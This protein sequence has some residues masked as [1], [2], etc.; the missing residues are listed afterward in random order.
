MNTTVVN[1]I[2]ELERIGWVYE[3]ASESEVRCR[4][5]FHDDDT[6]SCSINIER[7][8][9]KCHTAGCEMKGD[10]VTFIARCLKTSRVVALADLATRYDLEEVKPIGSRVVERYHSAI[11]AA[12]PHLK[13]L[14]DRGV[15]VELIRKYR[16]GFDKGRI[17]IPITNDGGIF[18]NV[19]R[20]MPG[21]PG[22]EKMRN[23]RGHGK[24]RLFPL[25]QLKYDCVIIAGGELKAIVAADLLNEHNIG[26]ITATAGEGNWAPAFTARLKGKRIYVCMD[27][28]NPGQVAADKLCAQ[29][30]GQ[31]K[32]VGKLELPLDVDKYPAGDINDWV[33]QEKA[34]AEDFLKLLESTE[35]WKPASKISYD[36]DEL[37]T[38]L[39]LAQSVDAAFTGRRVKVKAVISAVDTAPYVVPKR[40][41]VSCGRDQDGCSQCP[42]FAT[43][44]GKEGLTDMLLSPES[45]GILEMVAAPKKSQR[46]A[47]MSGLGVPFCKTVEFRP[48][49]YFN[50][51]DVRLSPQLE[52]TCKQADRTMQPAMCIGHGLE[53]NE[54]YELVGRMYPHPKSQQSVLMISSSKATQ[55]AL[56]NYS[57]TDDEL[58]ELTVFQPTEWTEDGVGEKLDEIYDDL[59]A[60]VTRIFKRRDL[61]LALDLAYHSAL[62]IRFDGR[63][64][65]GWV[66]V[67]VVGDSAQGKSETTIQ[68]MKHYGLGEKLECK[69]A[70]VAGMLGGLQQL[71]NR[72]FITWGVIP[73]HD[74][75][76]VV[77]EELKGA[78][79]E[80]IGKLTDMRS[81]GIAEIPK[82]ERRR[83]HAR[84]RLVALSNPRSSSPM[85]S[86]NFGVEAIPELIGSLED[87]RRFDLGII[88]AAND[89][90]AK[91]L[92]SLQRHRPVVKP[93]YTSDLCRRCVL[94]AWTRDDGDILIE[95]D[96]A[97][98]ILD[99]STKLCED[100]TERIP[101]VDRG[102]MRLKLAR[103]AT[104]LAC[105]TF[106]CAKKNPQKVIV[107]KCHVQYI[108]SFLRRT[109]SGT[110]FGYHDYSRAIA[111]SENMIGHK[112]VRGRLLQTPFPR[113]FIQQI[114][115][116]N[117]IELRDICDWCGWE[118]GDALSL[119][120]L[121]VRK[122]AL[123]RD[124][125][126]YRKTAQFIELLKDL[127][128]SSD[129][130]AADRPDYVG[131][132]DEF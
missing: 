54:G 73:T 12:K 14:R 16:L 61:H 98:F 109:Y 87:V 127:E 106:S 63:V 126:S 4:C 121:L 95:A 26:A 42:I 117:D 46:D 40:I 28:D 56:S 103:L 107:R 116:T 120:S 104:A 65:K 29:I 101:L 124:G 49:E 9:F 36:L 58:E 20:Y 119:L 100:Y 53:L 39:H 66:E 1:V 51:E 80:V 72:W 19:R 34:T 108:V 18:V 96:A 78:S 5:P 94:W 41:L 77:L 48:I 30:R 64:E 22:S 59:E 83:T 88:L 33:G 84:T 17:T 68:I 123:R 110:S 91:E 62:L 67:L 69:N 71:G 24:V 111:A 99:A 60:N 57:P 114:L 50:V 129:L 32:W 90:K 82:I 52:I 7:R 38:D 89:I 55:D 97:E 70:T 6:P 35:E 11:W 25:D 122:H 112:L 15:G 86:Y 79:V 13:E 45:P 130:K 132:L 2:A 92:N 44:P 10:I 118:R 47:L 75:R 128:I 113:D 37:A 8:L 31:A 21:A 23:T 76:L 102:S 27:I 43:E 85:S 131:E 125:R 3:F 74:R 81:S 115:H 105:R 93:T